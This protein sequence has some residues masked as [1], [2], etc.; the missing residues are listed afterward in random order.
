MKLNYI[1]KRGNFLGDDGTREVA[2][3]LMGLVHLTNL[4]L[5]LW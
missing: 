5:H 4:S 3:A 2:T 1:I